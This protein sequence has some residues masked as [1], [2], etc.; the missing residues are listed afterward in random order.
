MD[1]TKD[2]L[3]GL[4]L[5]QRTL[6]EDGKRGKRIK[7]SAN[8][9]VPFTKGRT[10]ED[11]D[12]IRKE[13]RRRKKTEK[14]REEL[15]F[16]RR[17]NISKGE[18]QRLK[19][20]RREKINNELEELKRKDK[21]ASK[22]MEYFITD[23]TNA[24]KQISNRRS[25]AKKGSARHIAMH[26]AVAYYA[27]IDFFSRMGTADA[28]KGC[29]W[30]FKGDFCE[31]DPNDDKK[32]GPKEEIWSPNC[33]PDAMEHMKINCVG[34]K[35]DIK[36]EEEVQQ[37]CI[38]GGFGRVRFLPHPG[39]EETGY[40]GHQCVGLSNGNIVI[41]LAAGLA[42]VVALIYC[43]KK[44]K[45]KS[46]PSLVNQKKNKNSNQKKEDDKHQK[47]H[48][49]TNFIRGNAGITP[50]QPRSETKLPAS[51]R[52]KKHVKKNFIGGNKFIV[53][54][55]DDEKI[56]DL[57]SLIMDE[58][59][60]RLGLYL[61]SVGITSVDNIRPE[62]EEHIHNKFKEILFNVSRESVHLDGSESAATEQD[63]PVKHGGRKRKTRK[64]KRRRKKSRK[65]LRKRR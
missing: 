20:K 65:T 13:W 17:N 39:G 50:T 43:L 14:K 28:K 57:A 23:N 7:G 34:K 58:V 54:R 10:K 27:I 44:K 19:Q 9:K 5:R 64:R 30:P 41:R 38:D 53:T 59:A 1:Y 3:S 26:I 25:Y 60:N 62:D 61:K 31:N 55:L 52:R 15:E 8:W 16:F 47:M 22:G 42:A 36:K 18:R 24:L 4:S 40:I 35:W 48:N 45:K 37:D 21:I 63:V 49:A 56:L 6:T 11:E 46:K 33:K 32:V 29:G 51:A 12:T 2:I